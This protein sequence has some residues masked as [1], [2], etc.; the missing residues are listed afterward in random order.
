M[1][2]LS[3]V[4]P[5]S[6]KSKLTTIFASSSITT[7]VKFKSMH[8]FI[9]S[10]IA[11]NSAATLVV[12]PIVLAYPLT[13]APFE[14]R[15]RPPPLALPG[16]HNE[17]PY[18]FSL[19]QFSGGGCH[20]TWTETIGRLTLPLTPR[21]ANSEAL[22]IV[23][24]LNGHWEEVSLKTTLLRQSHKLQSPNGKIVPQFISKKDLCT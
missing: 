8:K 15:T 9:P 19:Y 1:T 16:L 14:S 7:F 2:S 22:A 4:F 21:N 12:W 20:R 17:D 5:S 13:Q 10:R 18:K 11:H 23:L 6:F 24:D 3:I